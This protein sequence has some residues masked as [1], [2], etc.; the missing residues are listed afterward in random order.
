MGVIV[1][2][3]L[4]IIVILLGGGPILLWGGVALIALM[5]AG[6]IVTLP[7][8]ALTMLCQWLLQRRGP[9]VAAA[10]A[11][12][13]NPVRRT[14][15]LLWVAAVTVT[16]ALGLP[17]IVINPRFIGPLAVGIVGWLTL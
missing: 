10:S 15:C 9:N 1:V 14:R 8:L 2:L 13:P 4:A 11:R 16:I 6:L 17:W 3:L 12:V 5:V 7:I